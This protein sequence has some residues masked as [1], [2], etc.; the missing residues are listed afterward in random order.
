[1]IG[2]RHAHAELELGFV[3]IGI[4]ALQAGVGALLGLQLGF[5]GDA[6]VEGGH[7]RFLARDVI[8]RQRW[9]RGRHFF[10]DFLDHFFDDLFRHLDQL[11]H[12]FGHHLSL[13]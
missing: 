13:A 3:G 8:I 6:I 2:L 11:F 4:Q 10:D 5:D 1:M 7:V 9:G 12:L